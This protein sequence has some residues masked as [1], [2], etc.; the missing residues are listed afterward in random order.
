MTA[1]G[2]DEAVPPPELLVRGDVLVL[3]PAGRGDILPSAVIDI[4]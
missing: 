4:E 3:V 1:I 2:N